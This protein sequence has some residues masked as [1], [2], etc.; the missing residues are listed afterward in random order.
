MDKDTNLFDDTSLADLMRDVY[1]NNKRKDNQIKELIKQLSE[2]I[3]DLRDASLIVP[4]IK[5]YL[6]IS[7]KNDDNLVRLTS[8]VQRLLVTADR[9]KTEDLGLSEEERNQLL[10]QSKEELQQL[11]DEAQEI[12]DGTK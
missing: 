1:N 5:E 7:V 6:E 12:L 4:L 9:G 10:I 3:K 2:M 8:I 11:Q